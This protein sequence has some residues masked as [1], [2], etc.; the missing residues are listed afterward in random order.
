MLLAVATDEAREAAHTVGTD[1][2]LAEMLTQI[3]QEIWTA[4]ANGISLDP[5]ETVAAGLQ[6]VA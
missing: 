5:Y 2:R 4:P 1:E 3:S 6:W